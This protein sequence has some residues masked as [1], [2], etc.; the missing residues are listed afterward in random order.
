MHASIRLPFPAAP[1]LAVG[2]QGE[3][4]S[5]SAPVLELDHYDIIVGC[6]SWIAHPPLGFVPSIDNMHWRMA[7][8]AMASSQPFAGVD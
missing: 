2:A 1:T 7:E 5:N 4:E 6:N 3:I 8:S